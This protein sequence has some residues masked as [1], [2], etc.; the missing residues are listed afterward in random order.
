MTCTV[1]AK[2]NKK[3]QKQIFFLR[4]GQAQHNPRAEAAKESG[5]SHETFLDLMRQD[6]V[7]D[8]SLTE[9]G[10]VQALQAR[11]RYKDALETVELIISSPLSRCIQTADLVLC[12][13]TIPSLKRAKRFCSSHF[14]EINGWLLN[15]KH[16]GRDELVDLFS[17]TWD[18]SSVPCEDN[19][20]TE[21][22]ESQDS[23]GE[24]G[25][26]GLLFLMNQ[27]EEKIAVVTHGGILFYLMQHDCVKLVDGR[28]E[29]KRRFHNCELRSFIME[30][31][32]SEN[33]DRVI[34]TLKETTIP[35]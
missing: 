29:S 17:S 28:D 16:R 9:L 22:L 3:Y 14:R 24:R 15:A 13:K 8:A 21:V 25:Y 31:S 7:L 10:K 23:C 19:E 35:S 11:Q 4:H 1:L 2:A 18:F 34:I 26:Q 5:C 12:P 20:W 6:D 33:L 27:P 32:H 30:W